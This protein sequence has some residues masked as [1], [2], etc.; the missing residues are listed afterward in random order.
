MTVRPGIRISKFGIGLILFYLLLGPG[1]LQCRAKAIDYTDSFLENYR[2]NK[3]TRGLKIVDINGITM[4]L[5][6][7]QAALSLIQNQAFD[8]PDDEFQLEPFVDGVADVFYDTVSYFGEVMPVPIREF[9]VIIDDFGE[10]RKANSGSAWQQSR[11]I[12]IDLRRWHT[13]YRTDGDVSAF[14]VSIHEFTH[15]VQY[16]LDLQEEKYH[17]ELNA[18]F[19]ETMN[20]M[21]KTSVQEFRNSYLAR[22]DLKSPAQVMNR[23]YVDM[24][25]LRYITH[26][27]M[28]KVMDG[29][30]IPASAPDTPEAKGEAI[31][32]FSARYLA[33]RATGADGFDST[34]QSMGFR[35]AAGA[36]LTL[37]MIQQELYAELTR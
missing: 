22:M 34:L 17:R 36:P 2:D 33:N 24:P 10:K 35:N 20:Y 28:V 8:V 31:E 15:I 27:F 37:A 9:H 7:T 32:Q 13:M 19:F 25:P 18:V 3:G 23:T 5:Y 29:I 12:T 21:R 16:L 4:R 1:I 6:I 11:V 14:T 26:S 30:Y